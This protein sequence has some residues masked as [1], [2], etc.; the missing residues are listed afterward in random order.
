M[1]EPDNGFGRP[2]PDAPAELAQFG[3]LIGRWHAESRVKA[4]DGSWQPCAALWEAR[5]ILDGWAIADE[6]RQVD[7][8]GRTM[9]LGQNVR[10]Y[11]RARAA[12]G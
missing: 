10:S 2:H 12:A 7:A 5:Y 11:D 6:F 8:D 9:Q 4:A 3:F 1:K